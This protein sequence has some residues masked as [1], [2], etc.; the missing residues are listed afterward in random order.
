[1]AALQ[2]ARL[3]NEL[4]LHPANSLQAVTV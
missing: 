1:M 2:A 3:G 4:T